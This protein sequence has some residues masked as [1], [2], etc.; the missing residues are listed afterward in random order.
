[1]V[2][3]LVD[4]LYHI[5]N[6]LL[7]IFITVGFSLQMAPVIVDLKIVITDHCLHR[8]C[9][10]LRILGF[11]ILLIKPSFRKQFICHSI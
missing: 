8:K 5:D 6:C 11:S 7:E 4:E 2:V 3:Y 1:M 9:I 10:R